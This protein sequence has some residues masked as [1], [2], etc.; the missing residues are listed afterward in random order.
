M[1]FEVCKVVKIIDGDTID[2][3]VDLGFGVV[4]KQRLRLARINTEEVHSSN[5]EA[6][7]NAILAKRYLED[8]LTGKVCSIITE[9]T[10]KYGR[11]LAE[12]LLRN[13]DGTYFNVNDSLLDNGL[14]TN[15]NK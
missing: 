9:K 11:Y 7:R 1:L 6:R 3:L 8:I 14:A 15:Y 12:V 4:I 13:P 2:V 10:E 5:P